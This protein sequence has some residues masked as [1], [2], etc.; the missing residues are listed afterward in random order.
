MAGARFAARRTYNAHVRDRRLRPSCESSTP[1]PCLTWP[2]RAAAQLCWVLRTVCCGTS[3]GALVLQLACS[4][5]WC[6]PVSLGYWIFGVT[7]TRPPWPEEKNVTALA[8][9]Y[10]HP[11][12]STPWPDVDST[13]SYLQLHMPCT[14]IDKLYAMQ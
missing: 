8:C 11:E 6:C 4:G 2:R 1:F 5:S 10:G 9:D 14:C 13:Y 7:N 12:F 3:R